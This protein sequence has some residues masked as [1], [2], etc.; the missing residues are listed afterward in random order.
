MWI[1][2]AQAEVL[3]CLV[4]YRRLNIH[5]CEAEQ[6]NLGIEIEMFFRMMN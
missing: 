5:N 3:K 4:L 1:S 2:V 6:E